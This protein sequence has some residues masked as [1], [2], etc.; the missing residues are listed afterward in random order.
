MNLVLRKI[1]IFV[2]SFIP[3]F[4]LFFALY[5]MVE[6]FYEPIV[7]ASANVISQRMDPATEMQAR[8]P[9]RGWEMFTFRPETGR[10]RI[11]GW[12]DHTKHLILLSMVLLPALLLATPAPFPTRLKLVAISVPLIFLA[13]VL[14]VIVITRTIQCLLEHPGRFVCLALVRVAYA[15]GQFVVA[16]LWVLLSWRYWAPTGASRPLRREAGV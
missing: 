8:D 9:Q 15:S 11:R 12:T 14:S 6:P 1:L 16:I 4:V 10:K 13:H 2:L 7:L 3:M 5:M